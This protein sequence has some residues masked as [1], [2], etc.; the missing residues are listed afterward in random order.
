MR[1]QLKP[2]KT[3]GI[4]MALSLPLAGCH[5]GGAVASGTPLPASTVDSCA[6]GPRGADLPGHVVMAFTDS[7]IWGRP[8]AATT[9]ASIVAFRHLY[10]PLVRITCD[11]QIMPG[12]AESWATDNGGRSWTFTLRPNLRFWD[13]SPV[14]PQDIITSWAG[15]ETPDMYVT[16][17]GIQ[18]ARVVD[19]RRLAVYLA[20]T[21]TDSIDF[22]RILG[23]PGLA[24]AAKTNKSSWLLGTGPY[25][26]SLE[27]EGSVTADTWD[28]GVRRPPGTPRAIEFRTV[29]GKNARD[30]VDRGID[31]LIT[32]DPSLLEYAGA[33][34]YTNSP[35]AWDRT[36]VLFV[37]IPERFEPPAEGPR[38]GFLDPM[39]REAVGVEA[40]VASTVLSW[41]TEACPS[42]TAFAVDPE[43]QARRVVYSSED[44]TARELA[45]RLVTYAGAAGQG[46]EWLAAAFR[47]PPSARSF[48]F[49]VGLEPAAWTRALTRGDETA[50]VLGYSAVPFRVCSPQ[51]RPA[52]AWFPLIDTRAHVAAREG[53]GGLFADA[54]GIPHVRDYR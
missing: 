10:E 1:A 47:Q 12:L 35:L 6:V 48:P 7:L 43:R 4:W 49:A 8:A 54:D 34:R 31:V 16:W 9:R 22:P 51:A 27:D 32:D 45:H 26:P 21:R 18:R 37:P 11:D 33:R 2:L 15:Y 13:G 17:A 20:N 14:T 24:L 36:Y 23:D 29:H 5:G 40:R 52:G 46:G 42:G 53:V 41:H 30:L 39:A 38:E 3:S 44:E 28:S 25:R 50:Y 19:E